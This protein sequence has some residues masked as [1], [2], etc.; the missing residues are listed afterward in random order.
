M[1]RSDQDRGRRWASPSNFDG[2]YPY[3]LMRSA[4][5]VQPHRPDSLSFINPAHCRDSPQPEHADRLPPE[6]RFRPNTSL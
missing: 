1:I 5:E 2:R 4:D 3:I 6:I